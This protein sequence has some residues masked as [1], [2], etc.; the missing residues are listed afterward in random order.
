MRQSDLQKKRR[1]P[2]ASLRTGLGMTREA[3]KKGGA[4]SAPPY[5]Y[6][7]R[8]LRDYSRTPRSSATV[9]SASV[10]ARMSSTV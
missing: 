6:A 5:K 2:T 9:K 8:F 4:E 3:D 7:L 10:Q 1:I